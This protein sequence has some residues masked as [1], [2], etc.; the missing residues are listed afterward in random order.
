ML[1]R[2]H[3]RSHWPSKSI[4]AFLGFAINIILFSCITWRKA[5]TTILYSKILVPKSLCCLCAFPWKIIMQLFNN[6][7]FA[8]SV[9]CDLFVRIFTHL[10]QEYIQINDN[11][12]WKKFN[13]LIKSMETHWLSNVKFKFFHRFTVKY[14]LLHSNSSQTKN[15]VDGLLYQHYS[16]LI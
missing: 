8:S 9:S 15:S 10:C 6:G 2:V 16:K 5:L 12:A 11:S 7:I 14:Y 13:L 3:I 4:P 1:K